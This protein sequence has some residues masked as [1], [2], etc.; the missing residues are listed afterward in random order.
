[1]K[2][3]YFR[4]GNFYRDKHYDREFIVKGIR[5]TY[6][7]HGDA[8]FSESRM[9]NVEGIPLTEEW[10]VKFGFEQ[11]ALGSWIKSISIFG[12]LRELSFSGDYLYLREGKEVYGSGDDD[13]CVLWN[14]D[15][16]KQFY[17]HQLQNLYFALTGEE[18]TPN[19][20]DKK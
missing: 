18:L 7:E 4:F 6:I 2:A 8:D 5:A 12:N 1:M 17:V 16:M 13:L 20:T 10:L 11:G 15:V 9:V 19:K 3:E 14:K